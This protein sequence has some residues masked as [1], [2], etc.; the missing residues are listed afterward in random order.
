MQAIDINLFD[1]PSVP[2][3]DKR[4]LPKCAGIYLIISSSNQVLYIGQSKNIFQRWRQGHHRNYV[5]GAFSNGCIAWLEVK[6]IS[7]LNKNEQDLIKYFDPPFNGD[8]Q[9]KPL[10]T[11]NFT[12]NIRAD[13][14]AMLLEKCDNDLNQWLEKRISYLITHW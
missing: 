11:F 9:R 5:R 1:L 3:S 4:N 2:I 13:D 6:D 7:L 12:V 10:Q 14:A 8:S